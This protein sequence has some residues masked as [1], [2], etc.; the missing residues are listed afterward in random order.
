M[1]TKEIENLIT[2]ELMTIE[3]DTLFSINNVSWSQYETLLNKLNDSAAFRI[4]YLEGILTIMSP[5][6]NHEMIK[7]RIGDLLA[8]YFMEK[9]INYYPTGSTTFRKEEKRGGLEPDESYCFDKLKDYPDLAIEIIFTSGSIDSLKIYQKLSVKELWFWEN[10]QLYIYHLSLDNPQELSQTSGYKLI[11][12]S[13]L[14]P[15]LNIERFIKYVKNSNPLTAAK[16]F[17]QS[18][19]LQ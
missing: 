16:E 11:K 8:I 17:R 18:L 2:S 12:S 1:I 9:N 3:N 15:K 10:E 14:L 19:S 4:K 5:S 7:K 13:Q 6:I